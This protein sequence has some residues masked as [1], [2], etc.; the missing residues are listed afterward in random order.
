MTNK[1]KAKTKS[2][3]Q[4]KKPIYLFGYCKQHL[5]L[6]KKAL[7]ML[8][9]SIFTYII[10]QLIIPHIF[11]K[12]VE[13]FEKSNQASVVNDFNC[14]LEKVIQAPIFESDIFNE[15]LYIT[16][17]N[18]EKGPFSLGIGE[19]NCVFPDTDYCVYYQDNQGDCNLSMKVNKQGEI[20]LNANLY[21]ASGIAIGII[22]DNYLR[23]NEDCS[24]MFNY[25]ENAVEI[26]DNHLNVIFSL[27]KVDYNRLLLRG[28][29]KFGSEY[30][31]MNGGDMMMKIEEKKNINRKLFVIPRLFN[32]TGKNGGAF[33][34]FKDIFY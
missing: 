18:S 28:I 32:Y 30:L 4:C 26:V 14:E 17:A 6:K 33:E 3:V 24:F 13:N 23:L 1:C 8:I 16:V 15:S 9:I 10:L 7:L 20:L 34:T 29:Y 11:T 25:D 12:S 21:D 22:R 2:D 27:E 31:V 19:S 5:N